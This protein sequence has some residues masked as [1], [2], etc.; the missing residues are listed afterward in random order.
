MKMKFRNCLTLRYICLEK[1][2]FPKK[3]IQIYKLKHMRHV[4]VKHE[5]WYIWSWIFSLYVAN[6]F[7]QKQ[8]DKSKCLKLKIKRIKHF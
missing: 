4:F 3:I 8:W 5:M 6:D 7:Y 2:P 1:D